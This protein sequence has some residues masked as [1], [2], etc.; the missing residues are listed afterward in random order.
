MAGFSEILRGFQRPLSKRW[1]FAAVLGPLAAGLWWSDQPP[2]ASPS[3]GPLAFREPLETLA[4]RPRSATLV[5]ESA[6]HPTSLTIE[7]RN[8]QTG[9]APTTFHVREGFQVAG[10]LTIVDPERWLWRRIELYPPMRWN[11]PWYQKNRDKVYPV[12][13]ARWRRAGHGKSGDVIESHQSLDP[14]S[15]RDNRLVYRKGLY[16][17]DRRIRAPARPGS[18]E[19]SLVLVELPA[20]GDL[21]FERD[22]LVMHPLYTQWAEV[23]ANPSP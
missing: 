11:E 12:L 2:T 1:L 15:L 14:E 13:E 3:S 10:E 22:R 21:N 4:Q 8:A 9:E 23:F 20:H 6:G 7:G 18:Y 17:F 16:V 19:F 5:D